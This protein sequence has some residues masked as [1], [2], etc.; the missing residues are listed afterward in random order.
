[1]YSISDH[2]S[3]HQEWNGLVVSLWKASRNHPWSELFLQEMLSRKPCNLGLVFFNIAH[4][5]ACL[6]MLSPLII[7]DFAFS[8]C[9][10]LYLV[11]VFC[12]LSFTVVWP[13]STFP[14]VCSVPFYL[15]NLMKRLRF[16]V[17]GLCFLLGEL[18]LGVNSLFWVN[19]VILLWFGS[20]CCHVAS[21]LEG[22]KLWLDNNV[23]EVLYYLSSFKLL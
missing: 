9:F 4:T 19:G 1:M 15:L 12:I 17:R 18:F 2:S 10:F 14:D 22:A 5:F 23:R 6:I 20:C 8:L 7:A 11:L 13:S 16:S 3:R 21:F